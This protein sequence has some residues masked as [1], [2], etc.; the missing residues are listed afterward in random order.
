MIEAIVKDQWHDCKIVKVIEP[1]EDEVKAMFDVAD[2]DGSGSVNVTEFLEKVRVG[3]FF[4]FSF[5]RSSFLFRGAILLP[6]IIIF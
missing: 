2:A 5:I 6:W 3:F 4:D 1:T